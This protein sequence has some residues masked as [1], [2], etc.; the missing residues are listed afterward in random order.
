MISYLYYLH[1]E[2]GRLREPTSGFGL[3]QP[4]GTNFRATDL[5]P[6]AITPMHRTSSIDYNILSKHKPDADAYAGW[7]PVTD[8]SLRKFPAS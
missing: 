8:L 1:R 3:V 5:A 4:G 7:E 6:G 2:D